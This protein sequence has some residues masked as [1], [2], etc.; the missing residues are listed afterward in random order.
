MPKHQILIFSNLKHL[1]ISRIDNSSSESPKN[2]KLCK[3]E[4][5]EPTFGLLTIATLGKVKKYDNKKIPICESTK[6]Y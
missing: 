6:L 1:L 5:K 4:F 3:S 2:I